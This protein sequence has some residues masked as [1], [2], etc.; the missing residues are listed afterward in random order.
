MNI[1]IEVYT[2]KRPYVGVGEF[3][4][5]LGRH[6]AQKAQLLKECGIELY[7]IVPKGQEGVFGDEVNYVSFPGNIGGLERFYPYHIDLLHLTHQYCKFQ[8]FPR[9]SK[10][11]LTIHD[12][13]F[14]YEKKGSKLQ[15]YTK[16]FDHL[17]QQA[18]YIN[19][20]S[21]FTGRDT[22]GHFQIDVPSRVI[23]NGVSKLDCHD[24]QLSAHFINSIPKSYLFHISSLRPKKN[25]HL[26]IEM[27]AYLPNET[28]VIAGDWNTSY[29]REQQEIIKQKKLNN[30]ICLNQISTNEKAWLYAHC[31][32]FLFPSACEGFG[33]PPIEAMHF[34]KPVFLSTLTSL[35]EIG[36]NQAFFWKKLI[37]EEM[38][39]TVSQNL[40]TASLSNELSDSLKSHAAQFNWENCAEQY[41]SYYKSILGIASDARS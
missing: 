5:N 29:G 14:I 24:D 7:F 15:K 37:P 26:L 1:F 18:D 33:L 25:I 13:N 3:C 30:I 17:L 10:T 22:E 11:L 32:A 28:L 9:A 20:I 41:I 21:E 34:G 23:Y 36:G 19:Y 6:L 38:A 31:K 39:K 40:T 8:H 12:I 35:P 2:I 16:K 27:M 4:L